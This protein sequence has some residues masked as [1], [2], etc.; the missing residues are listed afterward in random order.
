V[1]HS[2]A[3]WEC[4]AVSMSDTDTGISLCLHLTTHACP[5]PL[6]PAQELQLLEAASVALSTV[7]AD[8]CHNSEELHSAGEVVTSCTASQAGC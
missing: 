4:T 1:V 5:A 6:A 7:L 3:I 2:C 8:I